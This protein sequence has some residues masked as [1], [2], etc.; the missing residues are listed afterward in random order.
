[1]RP[2]L[3]MIAIGFGAGLWVGLDSFWG[4]G[5]GLWVVALPVLLGALLLSRQAPV[6]AA[7]GLAGVAGLL[8]GAAALA[9]RD[10]SCGGRWARESG[11]ASART[12]A[13]IVRLADPVAA[14]GG[15]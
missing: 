12:R 13:V 1:M 11:G 4:T 15:V 3:L 14:T 7:M 5:V 8:W 6:A 9:R 10:A 2:P